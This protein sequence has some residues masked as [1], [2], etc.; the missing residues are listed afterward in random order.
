MHM[1]LGCV[2]DFRNTKHAIVIGHHVKTSLVIN[3]SVRL[4]W[5][6][7]NWEEKWKDIAVNQIKTVVRTF[8]HY[9][10]LR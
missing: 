1:S 2:S 6:T 4:S 3:P 9:M 8:I 7:N 10:C 5:I